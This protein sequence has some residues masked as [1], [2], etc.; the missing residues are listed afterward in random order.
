MNYIIFYLHCVKNCSRKGL[1]TLKEKLFMY[2]NEAG[3]DDDVTCN[4]KNYKGSPSDFRCSSLVVNGMNGWD[5]DMQCYQFHWRKERRQRLTESL[6]KSENVCACD[7]F[8]K[9]KSVTIRMYVVLLLMLF[10]QYYICIQLKPNWKLTRNRK[11]LRFRE[12]TRRKSE[13]S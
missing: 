12:Y 11:V 2:G 8:A 5:M 7:C 9:S 13:M 3:D 10:P 1:T 6:K 4:A